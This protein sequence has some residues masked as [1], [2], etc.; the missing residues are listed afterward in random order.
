MRTL[1]IAAA[2]VLLAAAALGRPRNSALSPVMGPTGGAHWL[3]PPDGSHPGQGGPRAGG[4][5]EDQPSRLRDVSEVLNPSQGHP[6]W[7]G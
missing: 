1:P 3:L 4:A 5:G 7:Q 6:R 2:L